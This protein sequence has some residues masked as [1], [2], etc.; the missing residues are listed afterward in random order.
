E[1]IKRS[2][3]RLVLKWHPDRNF[4]DKEAEEKFKHIN[5]AYETLSDAEK[6]RSYDLGFDSKNLGFDPANFDP[7]VVLNPEEFVNTFVAFFGDYLDEM[8]PGGFRNRVHR[9]ANHIN[10]SRK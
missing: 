1:D 2:Y 5:L 4:G 6:R 10:Q 3:K 7:N 8:V 9:A